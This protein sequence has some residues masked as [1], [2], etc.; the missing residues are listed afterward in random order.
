MFDTAHV[1]DT[2]RY[3]NRTFGL[4]PGEEYGEPVTVTEVVT[5]YYGV[6]V[7]VSDGEELD[8]GLHHM[9]VT[10]CVGR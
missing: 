6:T 10:K 9:V 5:D 1:G 4:R 8:P 7:K 3:C 2:V